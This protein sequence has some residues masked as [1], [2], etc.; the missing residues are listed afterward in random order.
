M[1]NE[2]RFRVIERADPSRFK[3][4]LTEAEAAAQRRYTVYQ[5][6]AGIKVPAFEKPNETGEQNG[7]EEGQ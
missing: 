6:L 2:S 5:Q 3:A 7:E 4:F 1:R